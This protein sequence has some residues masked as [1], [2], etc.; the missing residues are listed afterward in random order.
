MIKTLTKVG[1]EGMY[2]NIIKIIYDRLTA[3]MILNGEK[4]KEFLLKSGKKCPFL[5]LLFNIEL[6]VLTT[7][8]TKEKSNKMYT[9]YNRRGKIV[10][11]CQ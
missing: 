9:N 6:D 10:I 5:P 3:N 8:I 2:L 1:M 11:I 4:L 7:P